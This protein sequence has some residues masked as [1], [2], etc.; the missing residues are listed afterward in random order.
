MTVMPQLYQVRTVDVSDSSDTTWQFTLLF[1]CDAGHY[2]RL[3]MVR[4]LTLTSSQ[5][6]S[7]C[8]LCYELH[9][10]ELALIVVEQEFSQVIGTVGKLGRLCDSVTLTTAT[11]RCD[12][13]SVV[14]WLLLWQA[15]TRQWQHI[16]LHPAEGSG[17]QR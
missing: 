16:C 9:Q 4:A 3:D 7:V 14:F 10:R 13:L 17:Q 2:P 1:V 11:P 15:A 12:H 6:F 8:A 5:T